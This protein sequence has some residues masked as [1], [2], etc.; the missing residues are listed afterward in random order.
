MTGRQRLGLADLRLHLFFLQI[1]LL[2]I[3]IEKLLSGD[4]L[5]LKVNVH[6]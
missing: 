2:R 4:D 3:F 1:I 5:I 6:L